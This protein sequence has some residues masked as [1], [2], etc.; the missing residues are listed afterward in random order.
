MFLDIGC[1]TS[2]ISLLLS[3]S[4]IV[5]CTTKW[6]LYGATGYKDAYLLFLC[7]VMAFILKNE[8]EFLWLSREFIYKMVEVKK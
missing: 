4:F 2:A 7:I 5:V 3:E 6:C 8:I 1:Y